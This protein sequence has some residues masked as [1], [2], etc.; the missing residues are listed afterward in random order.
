MP[1]SLGQLGDGFLALTPT[2]DQAKNILD[3]QTPLAAQSAQ[4]SELAARYGVGLVDSYGAFKD[5]AAAGGRLADLMSQVNHPN[6]KG[7]RIVAGE[8]L[9]F[10]R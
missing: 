2:L 9:R 4:V 10:F 5:F 7:H 6:E 8:I 3:P 1:N